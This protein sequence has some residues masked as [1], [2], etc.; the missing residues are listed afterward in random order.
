MQQ[1]N[2]W[3][4]M[5]DDDSLL[6]TALVELQQTTEGIDIVSKADGG[7]DP[8]AGSGGIQLG[9]VV[10]HAGPADAD[11]SD[12]VRAILA[13]AP[14]TIVI[15]LLTHGDERLA[16]RSMAADGGDLTQMRRTWDEL[17]LRIRAIGRRTRRQPKLQDSPLS[18]REV[19]VLQLA[20]RAMSN[21]QIAS[22]LHIQDTTVKRHLRNIF[23]K[24]GAVSRIDAVAR[25][26]AAAV[27]DAPWQTA[28]DPPPAEPAAVEQPAGVPV[29]AD[30]GHRPNWRPAGPPP[31][32]QGGQAGGTGRTGQVTERHVTSYPGNCLI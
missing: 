16:D 1:H 30:R 29:Q 26:V 24:L 27:I 21:R 7:G 10:L 18:P 8:P 6:R 2:V 14:Y 9:A 20:A 28:P 11:T 4:L 5:A 31:C 32:E 12:V 13:S 23:H 22:R 17:L 15:M 19:E 3:L 25:A